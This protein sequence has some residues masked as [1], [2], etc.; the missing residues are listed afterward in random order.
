MN[1]RRL[2]L[3][4]LVA[5]DALLSEGGVSA[6]ARRLGLSQPAVSHALNRLREA[7]SDPLLIRVGARMELTPR[8][9]RLRDPVR[10]LLRDAG[11]LF[12]EDGFDPASSRR[13]FTFMM[14]DLVVSILMPRLVKRLETEA[15]HIRLNVMPWHGDELFNPAF[16]R[17]VDIVATYVGDALPGFRRQ[18]LYVDTD[19]LAVRRGH[20]SLD[21][22]VS[23]E[24]FTAARH[25]AVVGRGERQDPIDA[26]LSQHGM[27]R[28]VVLT[29]PSYLQALQV[30]AETDLVAFVPSRLASA[31]ADRLGLV[32]IRPPLDP[33][34]DEQFLFHPA[35]LHS[36]P[37]SIWLRTVVLDVAG[38]L[39]QRLG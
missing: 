28:D 20:P 35:R 18:L 26:W 36:D 13:Q 2:D 32:L 33:S 38:T 15:P 22:L 16:A 7:T 25:V 11:S 4:L 24:G 6:A 17:S 23:L 39:D 27:R 9:H 19:I 37:G 31:L 21:Q 3:N 5:L 34:I 29:A 14:P 10:S 30:A 1:M 8:A 12:A